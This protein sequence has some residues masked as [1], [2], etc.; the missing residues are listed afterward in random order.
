MEY[1]RR[2][3]SARIQLNAL[4]T[5]HENAPAVL[6]VA[7]AD[8]FKAWRLLADV[9]G[10]ARIRIDL[11]GMVDV[12]DGID[13]RSRSARATLDGLVEMLDTRITILEG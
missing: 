4:D 10:S 11:D 6:E 13:L 9:P 2:I 8:L 5:Q 7:I 1:L 12:L 3:R